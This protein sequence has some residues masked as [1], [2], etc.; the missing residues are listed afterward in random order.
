M[1]KLKT[2]N[3]KKMNFKNILFDC[4][5][6]L[7]LTEHIY[8]KAYQ[9]LLAMH[10]VYLSEDEI[11]RRYSGKSL[12]IAVQEIEQEFKITDPQFISKF[13]S[14]CSEMKKTDLKPTFGTPEVLDELREINKYVVTNAPLEVAFN[15]LSALNQA[16]QE[17]DSKSPGHGIISENVI[18]AHTK[19]KFKPDSDV[20]EQAIANGN[21]NKSETIIIEDSISGVQ[22]GIQ[23][24]IKTIIFL[25]DHNQHMKE[26]YPDLEHI[27]DM[28]KITKY[29]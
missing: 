12:S 6:T 15:N 27:N 1:F 14:L 10:N 28:R 16:M 21:L 5:G 11:K 26:L 24:G 2:S 8:T 22:A 23:T 13:E 25:N 20:F 19:G 3:S 7:V 18:S 9:I 29:F 17:I 4:D